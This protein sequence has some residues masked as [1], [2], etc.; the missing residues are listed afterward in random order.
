MMPRELPAMIVFDCWFSE[1][2]FQHTA[3]TN[4]LSDEAILLSIS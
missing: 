2:F 4:S 3:D 1:F